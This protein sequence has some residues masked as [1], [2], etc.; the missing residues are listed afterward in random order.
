MPGV[1]GWGIVDFETMSLVKTEG[2]LVGDQNFGTNLIEPVAR[3]VLD[4]GLH[5]LA[6]ESRASGFRGHPD[7]EELS[8]RGAVGVAIEGREPDRLLI[9]EREE[10]KAV[11]PFRRRVRLSR[12][13][14]IR[15]ARGRFI[16]GGKRLRRL[17]QGRQTHLFIKSPLPFGNSP[18]CSHPDDPTRKALEPG[19]PENCAIRQNPVT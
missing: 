2:P 19:L 4:D 9:E 18:D 13:A 7:L 1:D 17:P 8:Q 3:G 11:R 6:G 15:A 14:L 5:Q 10:C 12:P 16:R